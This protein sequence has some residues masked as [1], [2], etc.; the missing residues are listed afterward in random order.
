[1]NTPKTPSADGLTLK[2]RDVLRLLAEGKNLEEIGSIL[3][4]TEGTVRNHRKYLM[5]Y[6]NLFNLTDLIKYA[7][8]VGLISSE[9]RFA[10]RLEVELPGKAIFTSFGQQVESPVTARDLNAH[11]TY[12]VSSTTPE[13]GDPVQVHL[14]QEEPMFSFAAEGQVIRVEQLSEDQCGI[15]IRF[16]SIPDLDH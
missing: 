1:M 8:Q 6:L 10:P 9:E 2:E 12:V 5:K 14:H 4:V 7:A 3:G 16:Q 11:G 13:V 15:A